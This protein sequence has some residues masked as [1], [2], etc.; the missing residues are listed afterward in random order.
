VTVKAVEAMQVLR[1]DRWGFDQLLFEHPEV[2]RS[3]IRLMVERL[4]KMT[5]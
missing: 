4:R 2:S 5:R 1:I 3:L